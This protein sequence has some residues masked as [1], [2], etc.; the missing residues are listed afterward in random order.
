[1]CY[2]IK[3]FANN[4]LV[5]ALKNVFVYDSLDESCMSSIDVF[6]GSFA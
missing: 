3:I 4:K 6:D 1:M 2:Y 5:H